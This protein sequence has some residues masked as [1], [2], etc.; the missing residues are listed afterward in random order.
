MFLKFDQSFFNYF[1]FLILPSIFKKNKFN[2]FFSSFIIPFAKN[3]CLNL[4]P[5]P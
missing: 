1:K 2:G 3:L 4:S 5:D